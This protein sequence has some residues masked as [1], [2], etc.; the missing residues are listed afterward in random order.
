[1]PLLA[2]NVL[3][4][5]AD[6]FGF[7]MASLGVGA[8]SGALTLGALRS[9][10]A[11]IPLTF[12]AAAVACAGI[13]AMAAVRQFWVAVPVLFVIGFFAVVV[14]AICNN[15]R[16]GCEPIGSVVR[17]LRAFGPHRARAGAGSRRAISGA[18]P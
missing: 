6:G 10:R 7:L 16:R 11:P 12:T 18:A 3:H 5:G 17:P 14:T 13:L 15:H 8:V 2:R 9:S 1:M 4:Q